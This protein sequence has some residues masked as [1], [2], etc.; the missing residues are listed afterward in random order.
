M[1]LRTYPQT[2][3]TYAQTIGTYP[4][5]VWTAALC[6]LID[7]SPLPPLHPPPT[8]Y[9]VLALLAATSTRQ[10]LP[11]ISFHKFALITHH[12][13]DFGWGAA[14]GSPPP[15]LSLIPPLPPLPVLQ[16]VLSQ[17][18][19]ELLATNMLQC[20]I[21][22]HASLTATDAGPTARGPGSAP[23]L[24]ASSPSA[25]DSI[26]D[27]VPN[28]NCNPPSNPRPNPNHDA[29]PFRDPPQT[30]SPGG[31][32]DANREPRRGYMDLLLGILDSPRFD[33]ILQHLQPTS[34]LLHCTLPFT[35]DCLQTLNT[36]PGAHFR[37]LADACLYTLHQRL[38][39]CCLAR[40]PAPADTPA[41]L[42]AVREL[43][44]H[45]LMSRCNIRHADSRFVK[46]LGSVLLPPLAE[47][48]PPAPEGPPAGAPLAPAG[49]EADTHATPVPDDPHPDTEASPGL[50]PRYRRLLLGLDALT[51]LLAL[52][53]H[54]HDHETLHEVLQ[55]VGLSSEGHPVAHHLVAV[56]RRLAP[57]AGHAALVCGAL[58]FLRTLCEVACALGQAAPASACVPLA[59]LAGLLGERSHAVRREAYLLLAVYFEGGIVAV[60]PSGP[61]GRP[62]L[63][64]P[65]LRQ[66]LRLLITRLQT[67]WPNQQP[68]P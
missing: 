18:H 42:A 58:R 47:L 43:F 35:A 20:V 16:W 41:L 19:G 9:R 4:V 46:A 61:R 62:A 66:V 53:A 24:R 23:V 45:M 63:G 10:P 32:S 68:S 39:G 3:G 67:G 8:W 26:P 31:G 12:G 54:S 15:S 13:T 52:A 60:A 7:H 64:F 50:S 14:G 21:F 36:R 59:V 44:V 2:R 28:P 49:S 34:P 51:V 22:A 65:A 56:V 25:S 40:A 48:L 17:P 57:A 5:Q 27:L 11:R 33:A 30:R 37:P 6:C 55:P 1:P 38:Y 29:T